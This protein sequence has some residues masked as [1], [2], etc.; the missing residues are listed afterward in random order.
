MMDVIKTLIRPLHSLYIPSLATS[1]HNQLNDFRS[2]YLNIRHLSQ[3][4]E[5]IFTKQWSNKVFLKD[6]KSYIR[7]IAA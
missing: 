4:R 2:D 6:S 3:K 7:L 1:Y 5:V